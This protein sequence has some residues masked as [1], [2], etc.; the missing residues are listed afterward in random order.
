MRPKLK[1]N[2]ISTLHDARYCSA[3]GVDLLA[4]SMGN[5]AEGGLRTAQIAEI[6][7]WL[8][9]PESVGEFGFESPDEI[10][11]QAASAKLHW[12]S[13]P[14]DYPSPTATELP[15]NLIFRHRELSLEQVPNLLQLA[16]QFPKALFEFSIS[17][18]GVWNALKQ[19]DLI[20]RSILNFSAPDPIY[21]M[22]TREGFKP[23]AFSLGDFVEEPDGHL[24]YE[25]CDDFIE[26]FQ[27]L[28]VA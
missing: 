1:L 28:V 15:E 25:T 14:F 10:A 11:T 9:G 4:F 6:M 12:I 19:N 22:L 20:P 24:D 21:A 2:N 26:E 7:D 13:V 5:N 23:F 3:V 16:G 18:E 8:S 27:S 17:E